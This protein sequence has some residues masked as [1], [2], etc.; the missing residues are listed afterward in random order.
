MTSSYRLGSVGLVG[1][2]N[3]VVCPP[4]SWSIRSL[5]AFLFIISVSGVTLTFPLVIGEAFVRYKPFSLKCK[6]GS[7]RQQWIT[8]I[9]TLLLFYGGMNTV[10]VPTVLKCP[11]QTFNIAIFGVMLLI[12]IMGSIEQFISLN[13]IYSWLNDVVYTG[14]AILN[15]E[16]PN[17]LEIQEIINQYEAL[18]YSV[19]RFIFSMYLCLQ[20]TTI[21]VFYVG[22]EGMQ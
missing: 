18:R 16:F 9:L 22:T 11:S 19:D 3:I 21:L 6:V 12:F 17:L 2:Y 20:L 1:Y 7:T 13:M 15:K 8:L 4:E 5:V 14:K 10:F